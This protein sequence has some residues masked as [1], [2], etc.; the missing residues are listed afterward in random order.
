[1]GTKQ[2]CMQAERYFPINSTG[3]I[4]SGSSVKLLQNDCF[5]GSKG[6]FIVPVGPFLYENTSKQAQLQLLDKALSE[7]EAMLTE[8]STGV[9]TTNQRNKKIYG[10]AGIS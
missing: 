9:Q 3:F 1:M 6:N 8:G 7:P 2:L 5:T 4:C 10:A